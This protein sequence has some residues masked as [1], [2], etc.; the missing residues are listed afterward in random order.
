MLKSRPLSASRSGQRG[1]SLVEMMVGAAIGL[2]IVA[3]AAVL[4]GAQLGENRR[5]LLE[6]QVQQDLRAAADIITRELRR[7]GYEEVPQTLVW[8]SS[9]PAQQP[10]ENTRAGLILGQN[11]DVVSY[12]YFRFTG[13]PN[14]MLGYRLV[15][16]AIRQRIGNA[17]QDLTD[18]NTLVV[19]AFTVTPENLQ[20]IQLA[21]PRLC[22]GNTQDCWPVIAV[23][24]ATISITG[25]AINDPNVSRTVTSR[26]R[27]R[28][29]GVEFNA[30]GSR[31][32]P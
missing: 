11:G 31:V 27:V 21:C 30:P 4:T 17:V 20:K 32:C 14:D 10:M 15:N 23:T 6:T 13:Q 22:A 26:V 28:N 24:D 12:N 3:G 8:S 29:D 25:H 9:F 18:A 7:A 19:T 5:L 2:F 16:G 1:L